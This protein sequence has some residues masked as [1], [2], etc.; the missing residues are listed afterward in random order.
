MLEAFG[1]SADVALELVAPF[2]SSSLPAVV[3]VSVWESSTVASSADA[4]AAAAR[5]RLLFGVF[6][7]NGTSGLES[8][9]SWGKTLA[10]Q[11][12]T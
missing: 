11:I 2:S 5:L 3:P 1:V 7:G 8:H 4:A 9:G 6:V 12:E 10:Y